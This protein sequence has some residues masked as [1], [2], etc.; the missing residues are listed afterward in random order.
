MTTICVSPAASNGKKIALM[1]ERNPTLSPPSAGVKLLYDQ[2]LS[3]DLP[4][5]GGYL[6]I[7][8]AGRSDSDVH[9]I[10]GICNG[11]GYQIA[12]ALICS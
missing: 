5:V 10:H 8:I 6:G 3:S 4:D 9:P 11:C 1:P 12:W 7:V 2:V